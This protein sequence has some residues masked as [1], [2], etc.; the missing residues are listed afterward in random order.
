MERWG[1]SHSFFSF[2]GLTKRNVSH[3][4]RGRVIK[5]KK[6]A[7]EAFYCFFYIHCSLALQNYW[8]K[9]EWN[10]WVP[11][12]FL[13]LAILF[14]LFLKKYDFNFSFIV[15]LQCS[16]NFYCT[17]KWPSHIYIYLYIYIHIYIYTHTHSFLHIILHHVP[18][19]VTRYS[20]LCYTAGSH[21][22]STPNAIV[23]IY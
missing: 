4:H 7:K 9:E 10:L 5:Q 16:V 3:Y 22:F 1:H 15:D 21:C 6:T 13:A 12:I 8:R 11:L 20:S 2:K 19:Q 17:S 23:C 18:S 14:F